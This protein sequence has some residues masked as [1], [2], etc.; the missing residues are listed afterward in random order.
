MVMVIRSLFLIVFVLFHFVAF[1]EAGDDTNRSIITAEDIVREK[2]ADIAELLRS[3]VGLDDSGG[4]ITM[5]GVVGVVIVIDGIPSTLSGMKQVKPEQVERIEIIRG[6]ASARFGAD[7]MGGAIVVTTKKTGRESS[8]SLIQ[9]YTSS[10]SRYTRATASGG[11][12][13]FSLNLMGEYSLV[14]GYKRVTQSPYPYQI[15]VDD[16]RSERETVDVKIGYQRGIWDGSLRLKGIHSWISYGRPNWQEQFDTF[17]ANLQFTAKPSPSLDL[18]LTIGYERTRDKGL[19]D[20]GTGTDAAGL[21]PDRFIFSDNDRYDTELVAV[22]K[23]WENPLRIGAH[24]GLSVD[25]YRIRDF[26]TGEEQFSLDATMANGALFLL[27]DISLLQDLT[28][29]VSARYD[30]YWYLD[31]TIFNPFSAVTE[32]KGPTVTKGSFNPKLGL[33]WKV[34][35]TTS[36]N[37]SAGTGF[38][39]PSTDQLYYSDIGPATEFLANPELKP[40]RSLTAD[41]G[42]KTSPLSGLDLALTF[43]YTLWQDKIGVQIV[44]YGT[45][46]KQQFRNIG[47]AESKGIEL[48]LDQK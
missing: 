48:Q 6:A 41:M 7:G 35:E 45:P 12:G 16:E 26:S 47:E 37:A 15:T 28:L 46:L 19:R 11:R 43:F 23:Q 30:L 34:S 21:A 3:R 10:N 13:A 8:L 25:S 1:G 29:G 14:D 4:T 42:I 40:Q 22:I 9:G 39:P 27:S 18:E 31:T 33:S 38:I 2:P 17:S 5:R 32:I 36:L 44:D 24:Y 20:R